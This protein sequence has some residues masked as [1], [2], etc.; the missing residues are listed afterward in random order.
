MQPSAKERATAGIGAAG[1]VRAQSTVVKRVI[2]GGGDHAW[3]LRDGGATGTILGTFICAAAVPYVV[4][5]H[6]LFSTDVHATVGA[7]TSGTLTIVYE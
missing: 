5:F 6:A 3:Q 1:A 2:L 4:D 7:G